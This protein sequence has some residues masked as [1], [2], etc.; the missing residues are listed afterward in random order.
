M[1]LWAKSVVIFNSIRDYGK[2]SIRRLADHTGLSKSSVHRH[3]QAIGRRDRYP[4]SSFWATAAGRARLIR[5]VAATLL[6]FG[7]RGGVGVGAISDFFCRLRLEAHAGASP[8][9]LHTVT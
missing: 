1:G 5:L 3:L 8:G 4:E 6:A 9:A 7:V 2:Q